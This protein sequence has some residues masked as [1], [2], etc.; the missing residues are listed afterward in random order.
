MNKTYPNVVL[1]GRTNVGKSTLYNRLVSGTRSIV[2][3]REGVTRD[4]LAEP[5]EWQDRIFNLIDTGGLPLHKTTDEIEV[6]IKERVL[7]KINEA[8]LII[9]V[10][11]GKNGLVTN[12]ERI[13]KIVHK[14]KRPTLLVLNKSDNKTAFSQHEHD[15][16]KLGFEDIHR[17]SSLH[18]IGMVG[19]LD[20]VIEL[21]P[22][23]GSTTPA[24]RP[25]YRVA[26]LGKPNVGK[27][28]LMNLLLKEERAI[29]A[30]V[31]GTTREALDSTMM[32]HKEAITLTD[33]AGVRR[34]KTIGDE[35][36]ELMVKSSLAAVRDADVVLVVI[37]ANAGRLSDQELKL[38]FYAHEERKRILIIF[39][40]IDLMD[41]HTKAQLEHN[42]EE[43]EFIM[44]KIPALWIS[45]L[46]KKNVGRVREAIM[47]LWKR[48]KMLPRSTEVDDVVK[49]ALTHRPLYSQK[50]RLKLFKIRTVEASVP[51]FV[52]HVANTKLWNPNHIGFIE[53]TIRKHFDLLGC[54]L[55][56]VLRKV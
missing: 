49:E 27:S 43:Y 56:F 18:G 32:L 37:D 11:D 20:R 29:V 4:Y 24:E 25:A 54:P 17:I 33:T 9:F 30:D 1:V 31:P 47:A 5:V 51:T 55:Q 3:D 12:D 21:L 14:A 15:F 44:K 8:D 23:A 42:L 26:I 39:N 50:Q 40:K 53:N 19:L 36:E 34:K 7:Q 35:L 38:L 10:V 28:S 52:M 2:F 46:S 45:C 48:C 6:Q 13:A 41:E 16:Y 22:A